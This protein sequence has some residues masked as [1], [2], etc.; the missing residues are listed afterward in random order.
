M[1]ARAGTS[2]PKSVKFAVAP[3]QDRGHED[4]HISPAV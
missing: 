3:L 2:A 4:D 1:N